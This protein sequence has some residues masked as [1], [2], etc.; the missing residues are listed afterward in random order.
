MHHRGFTLIELMITVAIVAIT[1]GLATPSLLAYQR[2]ADLTSAV[3]SMVSAVNAAKGEAMKRGR[4]VMIIPA[5][6]NDWASGWRIFVDVDRSM[7]FTTGDLEIAQGDASPAYLD[8]TPSTGSSA[9][10]SPAYIMFDSSG[11]SR[12]KSGG[13]GALTINFVR[14]DVPTTESVA[15]TRRMVIASTGRVRSCK[16]T[17]STDTTC[18]DSAS[19]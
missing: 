19:Y 7:T 13:F 6:G 14:N 3:N 11:Y 18:A 9:A 12:T 15:Q 1:F 17:S 10:D 5:T 8:V 16:P 4:N 2:N